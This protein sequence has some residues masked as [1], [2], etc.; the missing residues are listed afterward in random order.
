MLGLCDLDWLVEW[1]SDSD[2]DIEMLLLSETDEVS[3]HVPESDSV[4]WVS[5]HE[6]LTEKDSDSDSEK[7]MLNVVVLVNEV[8]RLKV[9]VGVG[10]GVTVAVVVSLGE[11]LRL[12]V[13]VSD[14][15]GVPDLEWVSDRLVVK[16]NVED[17]VIL[18]VT[19]ALR[20]A[21]PDWLI[22]GVDVRDALLDTD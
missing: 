10:S 3:V 20:L 5:D 17:D 2:R 14:K 11:E 22:V 9:S 4:P 8:V 16:D 13:V 6:A 7:E 1:L 18:F 21:E 15:L 19:V 12:F